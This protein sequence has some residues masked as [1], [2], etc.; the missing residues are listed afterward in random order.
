MNFV[1]V[2]K[3][4]GLTVVGLLAF[5][6]RIVNASVASQAIS[7]RAAIA[8]QFQLPNGSTPK[9]S[10]G[11]G[12]RGGVQFALPG[13]SGAPRTSVGGGVRGETQ[14]T[15]PSGGA[16]RTSV[17]GGVRGD[18]QFTLPS[19]GAPRTSVGG[20]VRGDTQFTLPSN[21]A[22][23]SSVGGGV[24]GENLPQLTAL[25]PPTQ[26]GNTIS[27]RPTIFVYVPPI[28]AQEVFF[29]VQ[30]EE[31]NSFYH[32]TLNVPPEGGTM[33]ISLP[34]DAPEL[35]IGKNYLW[36]FAPLAPGEILRPD[37]YAVVGWV[38][39]VEAI[40]NLQTST[41]SPVELATEYARQGLWYDTLKVLADA[42]QS[43]PDNSTFTTEWQDLLKQVGLDAIAT[44]PLAVVISNQ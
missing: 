25:V 34:A 8:L 40:A 22:P 35:E 39:R 6:D 15:L 12:V 11:G 27:A 16:P 5:S 10:I 36:Y 3:L 24:R 29:S 30:D 41:L 2:P 7:D 21:G 26:Q 44:Q 18:T 38:K 37:N 31:G 33:A 9:T 43:Q 1:F 17:G 32:T 23:R 4:V 20:G 13:G 42:Q 28:G 19:G 14:F